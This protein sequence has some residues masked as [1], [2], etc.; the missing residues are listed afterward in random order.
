MQARSEFEG[1]NG[2][3]YRPDVLYS[4]ILL[5]PKDKDHYDPVLC[6]KQSLLTIIER[7]SAYGLGDWSHF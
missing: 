1:F 4:F 7:L 5:T 3:W 6:L 2:F